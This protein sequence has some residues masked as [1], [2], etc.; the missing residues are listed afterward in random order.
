MV[1]LGNLP[2]EKALGVNRHTQNDTLGFYIKLTNKPLTIRGLLS[3]LSSAYDSLGLGAA[4]LLKG[5]QIIQQL[6]RNRLSWEKPIMK[7]HHMNGKN[8]KTIC[9]WWKIS[10]Y[11]AVIDHVALRGS[12]I[13]HYIIFLMQVNVIIGKQPT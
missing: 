10:K 11:L 7:G 3:T 9:Q 4:F 2:E 8:G 6:C 5:K 13:T 12:L 1:T